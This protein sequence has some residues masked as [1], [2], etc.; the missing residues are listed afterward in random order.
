MEFVE[1]EDY[2]G[3][4]NI[5]EFEID[6]SN[7]VCDKKNVIDLSKVYNLAEPKLNRNNKL[8]TDENIS[9]IT[10]DD[11]NIFLSPDNNNDRENTANTELKNSK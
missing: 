3:L 5:L 10:Y 2:D 9:K 6:Y 7:Y 11:V 8:F 1:L 4:E